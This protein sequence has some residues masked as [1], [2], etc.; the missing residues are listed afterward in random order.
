MIEPSRL[1]ILN[2][3]PIDGQYVL[4]WMQASQRT[5][6]NHALEYAIQQANGLGLPVVVCFGLTDGYP[7]ANVAALRIHAP[8]LG[9]CRTEPSR[10]I[11][12]LVDHADP[13]EAA[14][15][16]R[17]TRRFARVRSGIHAHPKALARQ[18]WRSGAVPGGGS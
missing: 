16:A 1:R 17:E 15:S 6:W 2:H 12:F 11:K 14:T 4:Y 8:R 9:K 7:E 13:A 18:S 10:K 5:R 3:Q